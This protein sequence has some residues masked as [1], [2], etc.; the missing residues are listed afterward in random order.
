MPIS[1]MN[2]TIPATGALRRLP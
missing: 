1:V 2:N